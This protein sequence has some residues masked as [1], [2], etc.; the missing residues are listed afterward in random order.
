MTCNIGV[1]VE[2][3]HSVSNINML[4]RAIR[5]ILYMKTYEYEFPLKHPKYVQ[6]DYGYWRKVLR[7]MNGNWFVRTF[8]VRKIESLI[9]KLFPIFRG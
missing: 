1:G 5:K 9:Y 4:T 8:R 7:Q 3:T 6:A 2:T